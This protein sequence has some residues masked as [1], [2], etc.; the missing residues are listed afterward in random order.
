MRRKLWTA[1]ALVISLFLVIGSFV[2]SAI[3]YEVPEGSTV[4]ISRFTVRDVEEPEGWFSM[5]SA[6][7]LLVINIG[8]DTLV[9]FEDFLMVRETLEA[10]QT[11]AGVLDGRNLVVTYN[12]ATASIP[13]FTLP[14]S[15]KVLYEGIMPLVGVMPFKDVDLNEWYYNPIAWAFENAIMNGNSATT[16]APDGNMTRAMLATVLWRYAGQPEAGQA[17]FSDVAEGRWYSD[18][19]AWAAENEIVLGYSATVFG[20]NDFISREQ[21]YTIL[22]RYMEFAGSTIPLE[23][24]SRIKEFVDDDEISTWARD[25]MH[26]MYDAGVVFRLSTIDNNARPKDNAF[27]GEIAGAMYFFD[28]Y[29][30]SVED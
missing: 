10:G 14:I 26:F 11:L 13:A 27:R 19:I 3:D 22:Y 28:M 8:E 30:V 25:A 1:L 17:P 12:I 20:V 29:A 5:I 18:A 16:F 2:V 23:E 6:D 4:V 15:I 21:M 7:G 24:E 9:Y